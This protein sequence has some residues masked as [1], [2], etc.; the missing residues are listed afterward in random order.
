MQGQGKGG[1]RG[2]GREGEGADGPI[3]GVGAEA[4]WREGGTYGVVLVSI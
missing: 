1:G 3:Q 2:G 4:G